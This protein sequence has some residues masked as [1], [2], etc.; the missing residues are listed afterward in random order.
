M[1]YVNRLLA[2]V[3]M[4]ALPCVAHA[5]FRIPDADEGTTTGNESVTTT[6]TGTSSYA[7]PAMY[8]HF[9]KQFSVILSATTSAGRCSLAVFE[10]SNDSTN[11]TAAASWNGILAVTDSVALKRLDQGGVSASLI[12]YKTSATAS[13]YPFI[14]YR[15]ARFKFTAYGAQPL[16]ATIYQYAIFDEKTSVTTVRNTP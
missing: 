3:L 10:V 5:Q 11:W 12:P 16:D 9:A 15:W 8:V 14:H 2:G 4:V 13:A 6:V 1:R 7:T